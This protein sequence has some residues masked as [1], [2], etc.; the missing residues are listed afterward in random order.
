MAMSIFVAGP[1]KVQINLTGTWLDLGMTD[2]DSLPQMTFTDNVHEIKT[3]ASGD[4]PEELVLRNTQA[5][6]SCTLVKWDATYY[7]NMLQQQRS[8]STDGYKTTV[9]RLLVSGGGTF[10]L[11]LLPTISNRPTYTFGTAFLIGD[12]VAHSNFGN[13]EQRLGLTF[14]CIPTPSTN[15]LMAT[16]TS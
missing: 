6:V 15:L 11:K 7:L 16:G 14:R 13:V 5:V 3:S 12:A 10:G 4:V 9:G 2:N 1:T 8:G